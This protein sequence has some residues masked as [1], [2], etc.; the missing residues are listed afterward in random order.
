MCKYLACIHDRGYDPSAQCL[1]MRLYSS[2]GAAEFLGPEDHIRSLA[3]PLLRTDVIIRFQATVRATLEA[4][5]ANEA[6]PAARSLNFGGAPKA[7]AEDAAERLVHAIAVDAAKERSERLS[8]F[9][10]T[11]CTTS[12]VCS[13]WAKC[14][15]INRLFGWTWERTYWGVRR[16]Q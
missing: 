15:A 13:H 9:N 14:H 3:F 4:R 2:P 8:V 16:H 12:L 1:C 10:G 7:H 5:R 11:H 6:F